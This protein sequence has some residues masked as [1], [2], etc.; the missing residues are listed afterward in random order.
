MRGDAV[1]ICGQLHEISCCIT[2]GAIYSVPKIVIDEQRKNGGY[3]YC[4]NGHS[5]GWSKE[6]SEGERARRERDRLKQDI[7]RAEDEAREASIRA[8]AALERAEKAEAK[9]KRLTKR[10]AAGTCPCCKRTFKELAEH[11]K[12]R[13]PDFIKGTGANV[14]AIKSRARAA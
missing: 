5:Q 9:A 4:F 1:M 14:V 13:H 2:C 11:M 7:A 12:H 8:Q 3:H 6:Q 10:A